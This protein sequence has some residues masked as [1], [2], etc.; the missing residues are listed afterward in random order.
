MPAA[1]ER[2]QVHLEKALVDFGV[3]GKVF[4]AKSVDKLKPSLFKV[5]E[6]ALTKS[7][8]INMELA[9]HMVP[10]IVVYKVSRVTA[11]VAKKILKFNIDHI[12]PVNLLLKKRLLPELVQK[13]L[14]FETV[15][16]YAMPLLANNKERL[17][18]LDGYKT[19]R[20]KL[21]DPG[22]TKRAAKEILDL[23]IK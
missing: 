19:L 13:E 4:P 17:R 10:Q 6:I 3:N 7:G 12:S 8:T 21:G 9:I 5:A 15:V 1:Q 11:F 2:F 14:K 18:I 22:V 16:K 20:E 23:S